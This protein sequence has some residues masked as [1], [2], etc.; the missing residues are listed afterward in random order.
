MPRDNIASKC[1]EKPDSSNLLARILKGTSP[2]LV[3]GLEIERD[4]QE[5]HSDNLREGES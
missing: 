2:L 5:N 1:G 3:K 4:L